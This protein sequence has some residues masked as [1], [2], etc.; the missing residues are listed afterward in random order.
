MEYKYFDKWEFK[1][2]IDLINVNPIAAKEKFEEYFKKFPNDYSLRNYYA[3]CFICLGQFDKAKE[4]IDKL[5]KDAIEDVQ[6]QKQHKRVDT[7]F[8]KIVYS[9]AKILSYTEQYQE[10]SELC[11]KYA[12]LMRHSL[13]LKHLMFYARVKSGKGYKWA[14]NEEHY[15]YSQIIS[16]SKE[17]FLEHI[18]NHLADYNATLD[19]PNEVIFAYD[20]PL[21]KVLKEIEKYIGD[22]RKTYP[23]FY[24]N[25]Y[26]FKYD[27]CGRVN[28]KLV[29]YFCIRCFAGTGNIITM[30]PYGETCQ[31]QYIDI[32][33]LKEE[34]EE[35]VKIKNG[36]ERFKDRMNKRR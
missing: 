2:A 1:K 13:D 6:Y 35:K 28:N 9:K 26:V 32:N 4:I 3:S 19:N 30:Y 11:D 36:M 15:L 21:E 34:K 7:L 5:E 22:E 31:L 12:E 17:N 18:Q 29:D 10:L 8:Q 16:Y 14:P 25:Q 27:G 20:F 23:G 33:Y 24:D